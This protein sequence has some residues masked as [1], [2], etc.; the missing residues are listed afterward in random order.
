MRTD[1]ETIGSSRLTT[2]KLWEERK[3][4]LSEHIYSIHPSSYELE[5][6]NDEETIEC[7]IVRIEIMN[8]LPFV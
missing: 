3:N 7:A 6:Y 1:D 2:L 5:K 4:T 8:R